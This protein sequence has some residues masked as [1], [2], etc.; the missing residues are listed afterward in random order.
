MEVVVTVIV[1]NRH[2]ILPRDVADRH[3]VM[4]GGAMLGCVV[5]NNMK[6]MMMM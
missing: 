3:C 1:C 5:L 2:M 4:V 6:H